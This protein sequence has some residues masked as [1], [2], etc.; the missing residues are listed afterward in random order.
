MTVSMPLSTIDDS[1]VVTVLAMPEADEPEQRAGRRLLSAQH[2]EFA[3]RGQRTD[4]QNQPDQLGDHHHDR[5]QPERRLG[6]GPDVGERAV[7]DVGQGQRT[8]RDDA[9]LDCGAASGKARP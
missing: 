5:R 2:A 6:V 8:Q 1:R 7:E 9:R 3:H 4:L